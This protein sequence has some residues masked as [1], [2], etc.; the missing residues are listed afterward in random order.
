MVADIVRAIHT[1]FLCRTP[2]C[3]RYWGERLTRTVPLQSSTGRACILGDFFLHLTWRPSWIVTSGRRLVT[4][5]CWTP[6]RRRCT[7]RVLDC[8][9]RRASPRRSQI[10]QSWR[11]A[12]PLCTAVVVDDDLWTMTCVCAL[13]SAVHLLAVISLMYHWIVEQS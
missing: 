1:T 9:R 3:C 13:C 7:G 4:M 6:T 12:A 10:M 11:L 5:L 8:H 2:T